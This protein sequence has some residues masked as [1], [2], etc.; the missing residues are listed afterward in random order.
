MPLFT[1][2]VV[3]LKFTL[4][5][6][7]DTIY[8]NESYFKVIRNAINGTDFMH[9]QDSEPFEEVDEIKIELLDKKGRVVPEEHFEHYNRPAECN[10]KEYRDGY[11][12]EMSCSNYVYKHTNEPQHGGFFGGSAGLI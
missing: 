8:D 2:V 4:S 1:D 12:G 7:E 5:V 11:C 3:T 6:P 9:V 10:H